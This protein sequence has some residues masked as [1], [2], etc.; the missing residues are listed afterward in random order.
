MVVYH[1]VL[2]CLMLIFVSYIL[3][4]LFCHMSCQFKLVHE[5]LGLWIWVSAGPQWHWYYFLVAIFLRQFSA[6]FRQS[7]YTLESWFIF[8]ASLIWIV[9]MVL[10][11]LSFQE[12]VKLLSNL[13]KT[14]R[15]C[16]NRYRPVGLAT[17]P[18]SNSL[19]AEFVDVE[20]SRMGF[21]VGYEYLKLYHLR[22]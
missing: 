17:V 18:A 15:G 6:N 13:L 2:F 1:S 5:S 10:P 22:I 3:L 8:L 19:S 20:V 7:S 12:H 16:M 4:Q 9:C 21:T 14:L 11:L